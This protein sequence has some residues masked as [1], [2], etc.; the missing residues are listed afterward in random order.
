MQAGKGVNTH[1]DYARKMDL[2]KQAKEQ[3]LQSVHESHEKIR[4][5]E[6][7]AATFGIIIGAIVGILVGYFPAW[8]LSKSL[9]YIITVFYVDNHERDTA[10]GLLA[11]KFLMVGVFVAGVIGA[12]VL[13]K[14]F[15]SK[16]GQY[17]Q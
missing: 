2:F 13:K 11:T 14:V 3:Y 5:R 16:Y 9:G 4:K 10:F 12:I 15:L 1:T 7:Q 6:S 17:V 8:I